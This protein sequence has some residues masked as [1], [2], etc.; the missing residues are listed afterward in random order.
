M[1]N[2]LTQVHAEL[3]VAYPQAGKTAYRAPAPLNIECTRQSFEPG[4]VALQPGQTLNFHIKA[5]SRIKIELLKPD[6]GAARPLFGVSSGWTK[7]GL[8]TG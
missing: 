5:P 2:L 7:T 3:S 6:A 1:T 8:P 4:C